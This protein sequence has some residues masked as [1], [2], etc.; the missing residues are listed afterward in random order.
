MP[1]PLV[2][3]GIDLTE[4]AVGREDVGLAVAV[5][6]SNARA[7]AILLAAADVMHLRL[8]AGEVDPQNAGVVVV[9][10]DQVGLAV[11]VDVGHPAALSVVAVGDEVPL[12]FGASLPGFSHQKMP[13]VIQPAVTTSG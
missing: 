3:V 6:V 9:G 7:V 1:L 11:A 8:R 10:K 5:H 13:L 2:C 4:P 12:P